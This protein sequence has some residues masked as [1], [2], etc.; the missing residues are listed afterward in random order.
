MLAD[1][2]LLLHARGGFAP[3]ARPVPLARLAGLVLLSAVLHGAVM[4]SLGGRPAGCAYAALKLPLLLSGSV[5]LCLPNFYVVNVLLGL[6]RDF[7]DAVRAILAAQGSLALA[8]AAQSPVLALYYLS[9][10]RYAEALFLN[11]VLFALAALA[12]QLMLAR[13]YRWLLARDARHRIAL[14]LWFALYVFVAI[15]LGWILRPFVG[16]PRL[17]PSLWR[18]EPWAENPYTNLFW[19]AV[20]IGAGLWRLLTGGT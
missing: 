18:P 11:G 1:A 17:P 8:L 14:V 16:D 6:R 3:G 13:H 15:K 7:P 9:G 19:T 20:G 4:G 12:A 5:A 2:E 10:V